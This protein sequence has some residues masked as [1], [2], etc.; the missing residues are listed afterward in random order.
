MVPGGWGQTVTRMLMEQYAPAA[1][2]V[3]RQ[4]RVVYFHGQ[5]EAFLFQ[6]ALF[7]SRLRQLAMLA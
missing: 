1:V 7:R 4:A 3:D 2:V 5:T 6:P